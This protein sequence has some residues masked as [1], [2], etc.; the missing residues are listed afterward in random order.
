MLPDDDKHECLVDF[1]NFVPKYGTTSAMVIQGVNVKESPLTTVAWTMAGSPMM[2]VAVPYVLTSGK[3]LPQKSI[4][5]SDGHCWL[6]HMGRHLRDSI[7]IN[8]K[9]VDLARLYN[10]QETGILQKIV[11]IESEILLE[12]NS[13]IDE[14]RK[15][16]QFLTYEMDA[17]YSWIDQYLEEQY[18][19]AFYNKET[20]T[21]IKNPKTNV[22]SEVEGYNRYN[23]QGIKTKKRRGIIIQNGRKMLINK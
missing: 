14:L 23:L 3:V 12:G 8:S 17:Y 15:Y 2:T 11:R 5:G 19:N 1:R 7:F 18:A 16:G 22:S 10:Q 13:L 21:E 6:S 4:K 9:T 20:K